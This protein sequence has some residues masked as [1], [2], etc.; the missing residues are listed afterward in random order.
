MKKAC[1]IGWPISHSRS[2]IIHNYWLSQYRIGG[3]YDII[4]VQ[5]DDLPDFLTSLRQRGYEGCN[6]TIPH[7]ESAFRLIGDIDEEAADVGAVN[8]VYFRSGLIRA[9]STD[10]EG[11]LR[12]LQTQVPDLQLANRKAAILGAGGSSMAVIA[13]LLKQDVPEI[14]VFNRTIEKSQALRHRFGGRVKPQSWESRH[15]NIADCGLL[16]N[17]T[18]LGMNGQPPLD[19]DLSALPDHA[20]VN[21]IIYTPL[22]TQLLHDTARRGLI[23]VGGLGMLLHQAVRGFELWFGV[24]PVVSDELHDLVARHI[25]PSHCR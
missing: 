25:D 5:P 23:A 24:R 3:H 19:I 15:K 8:T 10:G 1:V 14:Q 12:N 21:D 13:A 18:S 20:V 16:V 4:P 6:V 7:K 22:Q 9:T 11:F 17:T 2:P